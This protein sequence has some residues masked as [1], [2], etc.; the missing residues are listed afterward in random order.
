MENNEFSKSNKNKGFV[1]VGLS[2]EDLKVDDFFVHVNG[3]REFQEIEEIEKSKESYRQL[4]ED[5]DRHMSE[6]PSPYKVEPVDPTIQSL[7]ETMGDLLATFTTNPSVK[8]GQVKASTT[9]P[10]SINSTSEQAYVN[11][12]TVDRKWKEFQASQRIQAPGKVYS[13]NPARRPA[14]VEPSE[15]VYPAIDILYDDSMNHNIRK[16][17]ANGY[18]ITKEA[19]RRWIGPVAYNNIINSEVEIASNDRLEEKINESEEVTLNYNELADTMSQN[20][21]RAKYGD[22][23]LVEQNQEYIKLLDENV[24]LILNHKKQV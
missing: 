2:P 10:T 7:N 23:N 8:T 20:Y 15:N 18:L 24:K 1:S 21:L 13:S 6:D 19:I 14:N 4:I 12:S 3:Q 17:V 11:T 16:R 5:L 22:F 9:R